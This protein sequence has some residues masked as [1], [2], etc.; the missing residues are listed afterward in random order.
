MVLH[1]L[2]KEITRELME[3]SWV[4]IQDMIR[5]LGE[6]DP[7]QAIDLKTVLHQIESESREMD[8]DEAALRFLYELSQ[9][10]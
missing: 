8:G 4:K 10:G 7:S 1:I 5:R 2:E 9:T 6:G 3:V